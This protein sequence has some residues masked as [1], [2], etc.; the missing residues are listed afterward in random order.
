MGTE[1]FKRLKEIW[2]I[3]LTQNTDA[4]GTI[5]TSKCQGIERSKLLIRCPTSRIPKE[6]QGLDK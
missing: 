5:G 4:K 6:M 2:N 1:P 3:A